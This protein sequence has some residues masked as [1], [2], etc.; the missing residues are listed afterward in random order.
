MKLILA[1]TTPIAKEKAKLVVSKCQ[2]EE[3]WEELDEVRVNL[4]IM[5]VPKSCG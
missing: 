5:Y 1:A 3:F 4:L 2:S